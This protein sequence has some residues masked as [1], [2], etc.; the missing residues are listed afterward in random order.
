[1]RALAITP[2]RGVR[3]LHAAQITRTSPAKNPAPGTCEDTPVAKDV[4]DD[5]NCTGFRSCIERDRFPEVVR[6][7]A[8]D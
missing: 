7:R 4:A 2:R 3:F 1:M 6:E 5:R 8:G